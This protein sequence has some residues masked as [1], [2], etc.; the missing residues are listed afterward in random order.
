LKFVYDPHVAP[1]IEAWASTF[2]AYRKEKRGWKAVPHENT[3]D[4]EGEGSD[5]ANKASVELETLI[6]RHTG[7]EISLRRRNPAS[8]DLDESSLIEKV[9]SYLS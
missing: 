9:T 5:R 7:Q 2:A 8:R 4:D 6:D 1:K 3:N